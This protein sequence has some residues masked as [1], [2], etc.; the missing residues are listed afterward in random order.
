[1]WRCF[2]IAAGLWLGIFCLCP[3]AVAEE[4][5]VLDFRLDGPATQ[6][7]MEFSGLAWW[8]DRLVLL[9]QY[10]E[11][12]G[13]VFVV[14]KATLLDR[15]SGELRDPIRPVPVAFDTGGLAQ[16]IPGYEG[17]EAIVFA[18]DTVYALI[19]ARHRK[20]MRGWLVQ[21]HVDR[22]ANR[23][24]LD[25]KSRRR[26]DPPVQLRN[27]AYEALALH[28]G[29]LHAFFE[30]NGRNVNPSPASQAFTTA[31]APAPAFPTP[32]L[33][34]RFTD[35]T[36]VDAQGR[37]WGLNFFWTGEAKL[38][39]P[40]AEPPET[41]PNNSTNI[42]RLV[43]LRF[44]E[45]RIHSDGPLLPLARGLFPSNWEGIARLEDAAARLPDGRPVRGVVIVTDKYPA[46][47]LGF[48]ALP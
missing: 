35:A 27:M 5:P 37:F 9:P 41:T 21:G 11:R 2:L 8:G 31:L 13:G 42:A 46:T 12:A 44:S 36:A 43:P 20:H 23:I 7:S 26:L 18:G 38:L 19:E 16:Q 33:E 40:A 48:V 47:R 29:T 32:P 4:L 39:R 3:Q 34:Y 28:H 1:M 22:A 15:L 14:E 10:P 6:A 45:K 30:A 25:P 17:Y 24:V